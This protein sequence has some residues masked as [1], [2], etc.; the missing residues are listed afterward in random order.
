MAPELTRRQ[1]LFVAEYLRDLNATRAA[2]AA[3]YGEKGAAV[4]GSQL[5]TNP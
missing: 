5:L 3:G 4:Q 2:I 1:E